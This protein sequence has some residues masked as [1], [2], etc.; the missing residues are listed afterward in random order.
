MTEADK[1]I[2]E[3]TDRIPDHPNLQ[4][5]GPGRRKGLPNKATAAGREAIAL[6]V[7]GNADRLSG[8][9][10]QIAETDPAAAFAAFM[11]VVEYHIPKLARVENKHEGDIGL[12]I[13]IIRHGD[14]APAEKPKE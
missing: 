5:G 13:N 11:S 14:E 10:D 1:T 6:F 3:K 9:L 12:T 4:R 8:W 2:L 7:D